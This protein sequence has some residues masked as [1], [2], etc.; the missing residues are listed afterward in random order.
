M[1][2]LVNIFKA[3]SA[4]NTTHVPPQTQTINKA[5]T[6]IYII[7]KTQNMGGAA[8]ACA[9]VYPLSRSSHVYCRGLNK[10][11]KSIKV[12]PRGG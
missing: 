5:F 11:Y 4:L 2:L 10:T 8:A 1:D 6:I 7:I 9:L 3:S 12:C